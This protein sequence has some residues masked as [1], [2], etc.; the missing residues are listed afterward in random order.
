MQG[1]EEKNDR[2][3]KEKDSKCEHKKK[4]LKKN[5]YISSTIHHFFKLIDLISYAYEHYESDF[6]QYSTSDIFLHLN[7]DTHQSLC[8]KNLFY[9]D[10]ILIM[11]CRS[12]STSQ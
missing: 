10:V 4:M 11:S 9:H 1:R 6:L 7:E 12:R 8:C 2:K 3:K 5:V